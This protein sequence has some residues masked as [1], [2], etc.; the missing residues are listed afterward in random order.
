MAVAHLADAGL[1]DQPLRARLLPVQ[2]QTIH[3]M[4][5]RRIQ[6]P[7]TSSVGR[8]F[9]A[10]ASGS[11]NNPSGRLIPLGQVPI[12]S[13]FIAAGLGLRQLACGNRR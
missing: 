11:P 2:L 1:P 8:L 7:L 9:D 5:E 13:A 3:R 4:L 10:V 12:T 6:T